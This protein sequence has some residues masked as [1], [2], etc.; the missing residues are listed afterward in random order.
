M[1]KKNT[2]IGMLL[3][4]AAFTVLFFQSK[5]QP[6]Q[7]EVPAP[8]E[9][10]ADSTQDGLKAPADAT[11]AYMPDQPD[12]DSFGIRAEP[13]AE[14]SPALPALPVQPGADAGTEEN[15]FILENDYL[16]VEFTDRGGAIKHVALKEYPAAIDTD[17]PYIFNDRSPIPALA[18]NLFSGGNLREWAPHYRLLRQTANS[19][20]FSREIEPGVEM[21]RAYVLREGTEGPEPYTIEH[22]TR[23][24][25]SS[26]R[27]FP[28]N[29]IYV[30]VGTAP[31]A[32]ADPMGLYLNFGY[33]NGKKAKFIKLN[34][35]KE[36]DLITRTENVAWASSKNQFFTG[37]LTPAEPATG[38]LARPVPLEGFEPDDPMGRGITGSMKFAVGS[39][40]AAGERALQM[41]YYVGPKEYP[42]LVKLDQQQYLVMQ[43]GWGIIGMIGKTL[44]LILHAM[45]GVVGNWGVAII[46]LTLLVR[47]IMWPVSL[48]AAKSAKRMQKI[49]EPMAALKE[50]YADNPQRMQ[51]E[52]MKLFKE[53]KVNP[54]AGC[55]P[56]FIQF[57]VFIGLFYM[58][59]TASELRFSEFLW[60]SDLSA[61]E[62]LFR[63]GLTGLPLIGNNFE[64]FNLLPLIMGVTMFFQMSMMPTTM[65]S[66][67]K[68][69]FRLMPLFITVV[70]YNFSAGLVLY[71]SCSNCV[72]ILQQVIT[73]RS[74]DDEPKVEIIP[75]EKVKKKGRGKGRA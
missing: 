71:W 60:I 39:V 31:A 40:P 58:L 56:I 16:R 15:L 47:G 50:K 25:N 1:D 10:I 18:I 62:H 23:I 42:R 13:A 24:K 69:I 2:V 37:L 43:F 75:P 35:F 49:Q 54:A 32:E 59:R 65:D 7:E 22:I 38:V 72:S 12:E 6:Q 55:L 36:A 4:M 63:I 20:T 28:V 74:R 9:S 3:M 14:A 64:Y 46:A 57:P 19:I 30:N 73:N 68:M 5:Q 44:L 29:E 21:V 66:S 52:T 26:E 17:D 8:V 45:Q 70:C 67:Q 48:R 41:S 61:P 11:E 33:Y 27:T 51:Q 53:H 34:K